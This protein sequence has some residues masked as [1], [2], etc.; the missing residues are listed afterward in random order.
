VVKATQQR[1]FNLR[2]LWKFGLASKTLTHFHRCSIESILS[3]CI[4]WY[5]NYTTRN[6]WALQRVVRSA[7]F[8]T[9]GTLLALQDTYCT[10]CHRKAKNIKDINHPSNSL[11]T[12]LSSRRRGQ[13]KCIK[14]GNE[15]LKNSFYLKAI[16]LLN[17]HH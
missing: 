2:R 7:Q 13:Y 15:R 10:R 6:R 1:L 16:I 4:T 14:A 17:S 11:F 12:P 9:R 8:I 5:G 3:G